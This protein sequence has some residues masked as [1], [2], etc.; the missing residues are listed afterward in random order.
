M[1]GQVLVSPEDPCPCPDFKITRRERTSEVLLSFI[2]DP[3]I[4]AYLIYINPEDQILVSKKKPSEAVARYNS[5]P[6]Y[7]LRHPT[8][9]SS[10]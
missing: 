4:I 8:S 3:K 6:A 7:A 5:Y 10:R 2:E 1:I 9:G